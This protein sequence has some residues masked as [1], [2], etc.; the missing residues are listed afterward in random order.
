MFNLLNI[1]F[2]EQEEEKDK[3][4]SPAVTNWIEDK[5]NN[6]LGGKPLDGKVKKVKTN[7]SGKDL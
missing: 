4:L 5:K 7:L 3:D 6:P 1:N 2:M